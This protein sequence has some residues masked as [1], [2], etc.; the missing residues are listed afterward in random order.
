MLMACCLRAQPASSYRYAVKGDEKTIEIT[1]VH[2][3]VTGSGLVLRTTT[4]SLSSPNWVVR[5]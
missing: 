2:Y 1:N 5:M 4:R 3:E